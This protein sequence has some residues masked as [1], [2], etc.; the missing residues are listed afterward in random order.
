LFFFLIDKK[1]SGGGSNVQRIKD[2]ILQSNP[3]LEVNIISNEIFNFSI[4]SKK[5]R[6]LVMRKQFAMIIQV[7]L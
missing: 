7:D 5:K 3:L 4:Y 6:L 1:V 2:V